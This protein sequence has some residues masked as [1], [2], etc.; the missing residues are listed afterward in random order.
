MMNELSP[1]ERI[2]QPEQLDLLAELLR[3]ESLLDRFAEAGKPLT[4]GR[5]GEIA[6]DKLAL[7]EEAVVEGVGWPDDE[8]SLALRPKFAEMFDGSLSASHAD[9]MFGHEVFIQRMLIHMNDEQKKNWLDGQILRAHHDG[10]D[11]TDDQKSELLYQRGFNNFSLTLCSPPRVPDASADLFD[12]A[13]IHG[14]KPYL[15]RANKL[16]PE[17]INALQTEVEHVGGHA[18]LSDA[19]LRGYEFPEENPRDALLLR[20]ARLTYG[21]L[22]NVMRSDDNARQAEWLGLEHKARPKINDSHTELW[23]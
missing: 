14:S 21:L 20:A 23:T 4:L 19:L 22:V 18:E 13:V 16:M 3:H 9:E 11:L 7:A 12:N 1:P 8:S 15:V 6:P 2:P 10:I 5:L 17:F